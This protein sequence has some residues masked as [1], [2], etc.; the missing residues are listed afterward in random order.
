VKPVTTSMTTI[1][2]IISVLN[3]K[4]QLMVL[5]KTEEIKGMLGETESKHI[6]CHNENA[7]FIY[8]KTK[9]LY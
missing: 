4:E 6:S 3:R 7:G 2:G 9:Q 1:V 5:S 8:Y